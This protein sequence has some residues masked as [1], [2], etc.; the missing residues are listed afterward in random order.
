MNFFL[1]IKQYTVFYSLLF[2]LFFW[3]ILVLIDK[4]Q[5][6]GYNVKD[7]PNEMFYRDILTNER[8]MKDIELKLNSFEKTP[9]YFHTDCG[10]IQLMYSIKEFS[11]YSSVIFQKIMDLLDKFL[12]L[13]NFSRTTVQNINIYDNLKDLRDEILNELHSLIFNL[14]HNDK[15]SQQKLN[16]SIDVMHYL[17]NFHLEEVR[18]KYNKYSQSNLNVTNKNIEKWATTGY[19]FKNYN[20]T[21]SQLF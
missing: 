10:V 12:K 15:V 3:F 19:D 1:E 16:K 18:I 21:K 9:E 6:Y 8:K 11:Q 5:I 7:L 17:L 20:Q 4:Y 2:G 13:S 14:P